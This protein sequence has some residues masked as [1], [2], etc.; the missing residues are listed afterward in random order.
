VAKTINF[1]ATEHH[2]I[3]EEAKQTHC[4][5][6]REAVLR[7]ISATQPPHSTRK[8]WTQCNWLH[9]IQVCCW[10]PGPDGKRLAHET[11]YAPSF[12]LL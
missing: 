1:M 2:G 8:I 9:R 6:V 11:S 5:E 10:S 7:Q 3:K 12:W 4:V